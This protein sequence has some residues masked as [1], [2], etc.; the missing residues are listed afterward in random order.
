MTYYANT[1]IAILYTTVG[2]LADAEKLAKQ[3]VETTH[4]ACVNIIPN[5]TSIYAWQGKI[6][7][8][9]ECFMIFK[10]TPQCLHDLEQFIITQH[11]YE[12]P[13]IVKGTA[14]T[15]ISFYNYVCEHTTPDLTLDQNNNLSNE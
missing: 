4:A 15:A 9:A 10:T 1:Q 2:S 14:D 8:A 3:A 11:P 7:Q 12:I 5:A 6:E 13:A